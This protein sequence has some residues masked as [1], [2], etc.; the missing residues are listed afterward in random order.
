M[1][2]ATIASSRSALAIIIPIATNGMT[3]LA[4]A[5]T[6]PPSA[7]KREIIAISPNSLPCVLLTALK[8]PPLIAPDAQLPQMLLPQT[9]QEK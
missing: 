3:E 2:T 7:N 5:P 9:E 4:T 1:A 8:I 6:A